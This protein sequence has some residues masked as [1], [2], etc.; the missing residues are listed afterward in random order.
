MVVPF[1]GQLAHM[2]GVRV[3]SV[4]HDQPCS[5]APKK[6]LQAHGADAIWKDV[7]LAESSPQKGKSII[8]GFDAMSGAGGQ[9]LMHTLSPGGTYVSHGFLGGL[10]LRVENF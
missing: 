1:L 5:G 10:D 9:R 7:K 4:I 3:I 2:K 8:L 6:V